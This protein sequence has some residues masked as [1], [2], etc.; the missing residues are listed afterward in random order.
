[1]QMSVLGGKK[2]HSL[3][4]NKKKKKREREVEL[5]T[6]E[7]LLKLCVGLSVASLRLSRA[8][9]QRWPV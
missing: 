6:T 7:Q 9:L 2:G 5:I 1:M 4:G 8:K 3:K